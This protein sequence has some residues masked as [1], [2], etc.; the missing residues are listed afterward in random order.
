M[1]LTIP[2]LLLLAIIL[3]V[4]SAQGD[5]Y[6]QRSDYVKNRRASPPPRSGNAAVL[7]D[8]DHRQARSISAVKVGQQAAMSNKNNSQQSPSLLKI[9]KDAISSMG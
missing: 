5:D 4:A 1:Q 3:A 2:I 7:P 6:W 9:I 8:N